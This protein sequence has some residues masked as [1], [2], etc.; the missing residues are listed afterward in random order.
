G[1]ETYRDYWRYGTDNAASV[2]AGRWVY[3]DNLNG[4][5][6]AFE[7]FGVDSRLQL[8]H[9]LFG[10]ANE[11]EIGLRFMDEEMEDQTIGATRANPRTG[12]LN[13]DR[14]DSAESLAFYAQNRFLLSEK[15]AI[16]A[17]LRGERYEQSR[18]DK[19]RTA[20]QG[21]DATTSNTE[22]LPGLGLTYQI[23]PGLQVFTSV[24]KAFSPALNGDALNGLEDQQLD[25]ERSVNIEAGLRGA[26]GRLSYEATLFR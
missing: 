24:Y 3:T 19:R 26:S 1:S 16:T 21:D 15:L 5:N 7:R 8:Q 25:A 4:N 10:I 22:W 20:E 12:A 17:G 18:L 13:T 23:N 2:V 6:R 11:A 9:Q 14:V